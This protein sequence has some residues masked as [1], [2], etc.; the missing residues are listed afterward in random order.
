[1]S[2][3]TISTTWSLYWSELWEKQRQILTDSPQKRSRRAA[4]FHSN[5]AHLLQPPRWRG[6]LYPAGKQAPSGPFPCFI[7]SLRKKVPLTAAVLLYLFFSIL[8]GFLS[9]FYGRR[10]YFPVIMISLFLLSV[11]VFSG[12]YDGGK[13]LLI[14]AI[15]GLILALLVRFV[16]KVGV[17]LCGAAVGLLV[18]SVISAFLPETTAAYSWAVIAAAALGLGICA[19]FWCETFIA[20]ATAAGGASVA[21]PRIC[22]LALNLTQ[23]EDYA[24]SSAVTTMDRLQTYIDGSFSADHAVVVTLLTVVL[25]LVGFLFQ[26]RQARKRTYA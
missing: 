17:F 2:S 18:G 23:L 7:L 6:K 14:G 11:S 25:F 10:F 8:L 20:I 3:S 19:V 24:Y 22:F 13:G 9:C 5:H 16:Y 4:F 12:I 15:V 26:Q 1:M 21:A